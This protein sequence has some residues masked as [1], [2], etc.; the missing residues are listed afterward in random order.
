MNVSQAARGTALPSRIKLESEAA[1][2]LAAGGVLIVLG[3]SGSGRTAFANRVLATHTQHGKPVYRLTGTPVL[4]DVPFAALATLAAQ[5]AGPAPFT[6]PPSF[7]GTAPFVGAAPRIASPAHLMASLTHSLAS[8][9]STVLLDNAEDIDLESTAA[10]AQL[11][12][13]SVLPLVCVARTIAAFPAPLRRLAVSAQAHRVELASLNTLDALV[14]LEELFGGRVNTS[15]ASTLLAFS[16]GNA[17]QLRELALDAQGDNSLTRS[18]AYWTL[19]SQ[20]RPRGSRISDLI[21]TRLSEQPKE[22]RE[23]VELLAL[24]GELPQDVAHLLIPAELLD[25][26]HD[27]GLIHICS[28]GGSTAGAPVISRVALDSALTPHTVLATLGRSTLRAHSARIR[29]ALP[30]ADMHPHTRI[31]LALHSQDLDVLSSPLELLEDAKLANHA[32]QFDAVLV[33]TRI[34]DEQRFQTWSDDASRTA[35]MITRAEA[36]HETGRPRPA[37]AVLAPLLELGV[38]AARLRAAWIIFSGLG[39]LKEALAQLAPRPNDNEEIHAFARLLHLV[40]NHVTDREA[41]AADAKNPLLSPDLRL[42]IHSQLLVET[43]YC[44]MP[45]TALREI[46]NLID[47]SLWQSASPTARGEILHAIHVASLSHGNPHAGL[48]EISHRLDWTDLAVDHAVFLTAQ[49]STALEKGDAAQAL[50]LSG[51]ALALVSPIDPHHLTGLIAAYGA[52]AAAMVDDRERST[53][54]YA[55][56]HAAPVTG[57]HGLRAD[58][59][60]TLLTADLYLNGPSSATQVWKRLALDAQKRG[61]H[62]LA[63]RLAHDAWRLGLHNDISTLS[64]CAKGVEGALAGTLQRYEEVLGAHPES[65]ED[66]IAEHTA[67]ERPLYAAELAQRAANLARDRGH[68]ALASRLLGVSAELSRPLA[69]VN[70]PALERTRINLALLTERER[71]V[72]VR[73]AAGAS[74]VAIAE[75]L[76]LSPRTV[77]GHLQRAYT[78]LAVTDRRQLLPL[79]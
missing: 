23:A 37:L 57:G 61:R 32:R 78:K 46:G 47:G 38:D 5:L 7:A 35:L 59:E 70:T 53:E 50:D 60:R 69:G 11:A 44:G 42:R 41:L 19:R 34:V 45:S 75:E 58:A 13:S 15:T 40:G 18:K 74:N 31:S 26:A 16:G 1:R 8:R 63:L 25:Q 55:L 21:A 36:L 12:A 49:A 29:T 66:V 65:V 27:A 54:F 39:D 10:F 3:Q 71:E 76:Y 9:P 64:H 56:F 28:N 2:A 48:A 77:E 30:R 43:S 79:G 14:L 52:A 4:R 68:R 6:G 17:L 51:Q 62:L 33:L 73:A 67:C 20:W 72:C 24:T 22:L